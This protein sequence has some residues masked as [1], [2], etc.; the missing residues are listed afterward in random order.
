MKKMIIAGLLTLAIAGAA[1]AAGT[2]TL[3]GSVNGLNWYVWAKASGANDGIAAAV[4]NISGVPAGT[5][6]NLNK[7]KIDGIQIGTTSLVLMNDY[8]WDSSDPDPGNHF[9]YNAGTFGFQKLQGAAS[10]DITAS[11]RIEMQFGEDVT[12]DTGQLN[13]FGDAMYNTRNIGK[14][15]ISF[16]YVANE[17]N[18]GDDTTLPTY[19]V[20]TETNFNAT[21]GIL[22][23]HGTFTTGNVPGFVGLD[24]A[25][26][27]NNGSTGANLWDGIGMADHA[28]LDGSA[29][30]GNVLVFNVHQDGSF[31]PE[32]ATMA[33]LGLGGLMTLIRRRRHA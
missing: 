14:S 29:E 18:A 21:L 10:T 4:L 31:L 28:T 15:V 7:A 19:S 12:A 30:G 32:P 22:L 20:Y 8:I 2:V 11:N 16:H 6:T 5:T 13:S 27:T 24:K 33:L 23:A 25:G 26:N 1:S 3:T 17:A 9:A